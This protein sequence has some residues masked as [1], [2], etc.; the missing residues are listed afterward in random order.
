[1]FSKS[2]KAT[3][4]NLLIA[5]RHL[6]VIKETKTCHMP[7]SFQMSFFFWIVYNDIYNNV[8]KCI[9]KYDSRYKFQMI[10]LQ[11]VN[12]SYRNQSPCKKRYN[13]KHKPQSWRIF[14][15]LS[16]HCVWNIIAR[17]VSYRMISFI[18]ENLNSLFY[19][20]IYKWW[21]EFLTQT[22]LLSWEKKL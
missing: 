14:G 7:N 8:F 18:Q 12:E 22:L 16:R 20:H 1:M 17:C 5:H 19:L 21:F 6:I 11:S 10:K 4:G 2:K 3:V 15:L 13:Q 9:F